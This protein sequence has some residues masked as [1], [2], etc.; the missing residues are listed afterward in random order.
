MSRSNFDVENM[1]KKNYNDANDE[2]VLLVIISMYIRDRL[3]KSNSL[4]DVICILPFSLFSLK[5]LHAHSLIHHTFTSNPQNFDRHHTSTAN[6]SRTHCTLG[7]PVSSSYPQ[8]WGRTPGN[9]LR[10]TIWC[11]NVS[12]EGRDEERRGRFVTC[13]LLSSFRHCPLLFLSLCFHGRSI[14]GRES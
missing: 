4:R 10:P 1:L 3:S 6:I 13:A 2:N 9:K 11:Q 8:L 14:G 5:H 7:H 12:L